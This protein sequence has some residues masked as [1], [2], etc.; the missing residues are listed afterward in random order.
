LEKEAQAFGFAIHISVITF[1]MTLYIVLSIPYSFSLF[2]Y[3]FRML[4]QY[5]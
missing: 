3:V 1:F 2:Y 5:A 4:Q